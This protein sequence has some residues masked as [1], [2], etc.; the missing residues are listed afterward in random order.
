MTYNSFQET[1]I[2]VCKNDPSSARESVRVLD[3]HSSSW[4]EQVGRGVEEDSRE[5]VEGASLVGGTGLRQ[6]RSMRI[7]K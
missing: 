1:S 5:V 2:F 3:V 6:W 4:E 7:T